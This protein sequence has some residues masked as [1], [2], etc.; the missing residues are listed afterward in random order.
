MLRLTAEDHHAPGYA[1]NEATEVLL[2]TDWGGRDDWY[3][4]MLGDS[5]LGRPFD[6]MR[7][8]DPLSRPVK[9]DEA[10]WVPRLI[11]LL[12]DKGPLR[13]NVANILAASCD[14]EHRKKRP[15][16]R[17][18][19]MALIPW[20]HD[21]QWADDVT[22]P[23]SPRT[24]YISSLGSIDLKE[25][26]PGL[27][28]VVQNEQGY[29]ASCAAE[30]LAHFRD[31]RALPALRKALPGHQTGGWA[32]EAFL[33]AINACGGVTPSEAVEA[34][35]MYAR[36]VST[37]EGR[38]KVNRDLTGV[39]HPIDARTALGI[40]LAH[41]GTDDECVV[42]A[43]APRI[44]ALRA[45]TPDI[46]RAL[47]RPLFAWS[48]P[49]ARR[50]VVTRLADPDLADS[51]FRMAL[52][53]RNLLA[54]TCRGELRTLAGTGG[55]A[56]GRA[57]AILGDA[58]L[59]REA[60]QGQDSRTTLAI[61]RAAIATYSREEHDSGDWR[62]FARGGCR[63]PLA[64]PL[65]AVGPLLASSHAEIATAARAWLRHEGGD[66]A[67]AWLETRR[68]E[69]PRLPRAAI[70]HHYNIQGVSL[71]MTQT[72]VQHL[73]GIPSAVPNRKREIEAHKTKTG[74]RIQ[75]TRP[76]TN[77]E[78]SKD[79]RV[80]ALKGMSLRDGTKEVVSPMATAA[81]VRLL[82]GRPDRET[83]GHVIFTIGGFFLHYRRQGTLMVFAFTDHS[84]SK[85]DRAPLFGITLIDEAGYKALHP[86]FF[87]SPES[88]R[89]GGR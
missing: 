63:E 42:S 76:A 88:V 87:A 74:M 39:D 81:D 34:L 85:E 35:E 29:A 82:L 10:R 15:V 5:T 47:E 49:A 60:L 14:S 72:Q 11:P 8:H 41:N 77:I 89:S 20:L 16:R 54:D 44:A 51:L 33:H 23:P 61:L 45:A 7:V 26:I 3:L 25:A 58:N 38:K 64:L 57:A 48:L 27:I 17:D 43:L 30:E 55:V 73:W 24:A 21:V 52:N 32:D 67:R 40:Y 13:S 66:V 65:D 68:G 84:F 56:A 46:A 53:A 83:Q 50:Y 22:Y 28:D 59:L 86:E 12:R 31:P 70:R 9:S 78:Y 79:G 1:R 37:P 19:A 80:V 36:L 6:G 71:G 2:A 62:V 18:V 69:K 4:K 75:V